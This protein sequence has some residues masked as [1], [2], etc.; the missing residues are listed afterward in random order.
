[1]ESSSEFVIKPSGSMKCWETIV[2]RVTISSIEFV[3]WILPIFSQ[4]GYNFLYSSLTNCSD[5]LH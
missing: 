2:S 5:G 1:V 3:L 4:L